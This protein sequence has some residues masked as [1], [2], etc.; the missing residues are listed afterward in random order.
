[1]ARSLRSIACLALALALVALACAK[2]GQFEAVRDL[3]DGHGL[4]GIEPGTQFSWSLPNSHRGEFSEVKQ[5]RA[6][7]LPD[8]V[9]VTLVMGRERQSGAWR[10]LY[11]TRKR[12]GHWE[13]VALAPATP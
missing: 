6:T 8:K 10:V 5:L 4:A 11:A 1:M 12:E 2:P 13:P 7:L 3:V 9:P